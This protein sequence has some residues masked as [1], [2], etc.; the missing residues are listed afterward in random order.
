MQVKI[1]TT[2][3]NISAYGGLNF[4]SE[5]FNKLDFSSLIEDQL[6]TRPLHSEFSYSDVIKNLWMLFL[7]GG[8]CAEDIQEH[9]KSDFLQIPNLKVCSPHTIVHVLKNLA[10]PKEV[11]ISNSG[12]EHQFSTHKNL[13]ALNLNML[14]K[15]RILEKNKYYDFDFDHQFIPCEK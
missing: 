8:D 14:L 7:A 12:I 2:S 10:Q 11:H 6:G 1:T 15:T 5:I 9:L 4:I 13:N 3:E